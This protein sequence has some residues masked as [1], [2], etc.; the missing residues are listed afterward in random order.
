M[1]EEYRDFLSGIRNS[2]ILST[3]Q[4]IK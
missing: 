3:R 2:L 4:K 1:F